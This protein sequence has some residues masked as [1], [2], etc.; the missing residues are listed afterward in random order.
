MMNIKRIIAYGVYYGVYFSAF[1]M[2]CLTLKHY[3]NS[4][5]WKEALTLT[6]IWFVAIRPLMDYIET[7]IDKYIG[8]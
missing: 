6:I 2:L 3:F 1:Y 7:K 5:I 8:T 4:S